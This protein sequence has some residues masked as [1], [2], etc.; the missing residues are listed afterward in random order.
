MDEN[1]LVKGKTP[2]KLK[3]SD[4]KSTEPVDITK[5]V[6]SASSATQPFNAVQ[7]LGPTDRSMRQIEEEQRRFRELTQPPVGV[8]KVLDEMEQHR[9]RM[10]DAIG[11]FGGMQKVYDDLE[12]QRSRI[13]AMRMPT[14][15]GNEVEV[16]PLRMPSI[17]PNPILKTNKKL[18][19]IEAKFEQMLTVMSGAANIATDIQGHAAHFLE[20][21]D[22][23]SEQTD[24]SA[25]G[26]VR[27]AIIAMVISVVTP[28]IPMAVD[29]IWQDDTPAKLES[30]TRQIIE[31]Q[32]DDRT[33]S[34][35]LLQQ[36]LQTNR[37]SADRVA[38]ALRLRDEQMS[39]V[40]E[41]IR[42]I[43]KQSG[44]LSPP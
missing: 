19:D 44:E 25:R 15:F 38:E 34:D 28:F 43:A 18:E 8:Q 6:H 23:A 20:K 16:K 35:K 17:P 26:A 11:P 12:A 36:L 31:R 22:K 42:K 41:D 39:K 32:S 30:L 21:F 1:D 13:N 9:K 33:A 7:D 2:Y 27:V 10:A 37:D 14:D 40:L 5:Y 29:Y 4:L 24:R 3:L